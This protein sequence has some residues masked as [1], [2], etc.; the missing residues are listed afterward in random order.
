MCVCCR[1]GALAFEARELLPINKRKLGNSFAYLCGWSGMVNSNIIEENRVRAAN[2][3]EDSIVPLCGGLVRDSQ[4]AAGV[5][6]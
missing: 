1:G 2:I 6:V 4:R 5:D 3:E